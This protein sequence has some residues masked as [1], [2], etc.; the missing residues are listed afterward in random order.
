MLAFLAYVI[1]YF[2][3]VNNYIGQE[4]IIDFLPGMVS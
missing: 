3:Q 2:A 1:T 4:K